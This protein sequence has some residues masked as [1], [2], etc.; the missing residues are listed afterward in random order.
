MARFKGQLHISNPR[1][2]VTLDELL[3]VLLVLTLL[4]AVSIPRAVAFEKSRDLIS[5]RT[6]IER[7]GNEARAEAAKD[8]VP[9][10]IR[11]SDNSLI[12]EKVT[13][14]SDTGV[15]DTDSTG[16]QVKQLTLDSS[17][18]ITRVQL[19]GQ[20]SDIGSFRWIVFPDGTSDEAGIEFKI[21]SQY[22]NLMFHE[23]GSSQW[24][25]GELEDMTRDKWDAGSLSTRS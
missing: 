15:I 9:I 10:Q 16:D 24:Q 11:I 19:N 7:I 13:I 12:L 21:D 4:A 18:Q 2:A 5:Q 8:K 14:D 17:I 6:G 25:G 3:V 20:N 22:F 23:D 1:S